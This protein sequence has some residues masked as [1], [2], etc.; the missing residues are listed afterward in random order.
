MNT[1]ILLCIYDSL[2]EFRYIPW[3]G[4]CIPDYLHSQS[5]RTNIF[6]RAPKLF[7]PPQTSLC[8]RVNVSALK[9][10]NIQWRDIAR[11]CVIG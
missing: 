6:R 7:S 5:S 1:Q 2:T 10:I 11:L 8:A 9:G 4:A 3:S